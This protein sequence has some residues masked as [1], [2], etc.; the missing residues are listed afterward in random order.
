MEKHFRIHQQDIYTCGRCICNSYNMTYLHASGKAQVPKLYITNMLHFW[1]SKH[2]VPV[3]QSLYTYCDC[4]LFTFVTAFSLL[5]YL[6]YVICGICKTY[7]LTTVHVFHC[8]NNLNKRS[9]LT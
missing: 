2:E 8:V 9:M 6:R 4:G 5:K 7:T 1:H 3:N